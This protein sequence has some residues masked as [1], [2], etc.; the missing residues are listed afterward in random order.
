MRVKFDR[1][2]DAIYVTLRDGVYCR[3]KEL[4]D[5]RRI[6][7]DADGTPIGIELLFVSHGVIVDDLPLSEQVAAELAN[8]KIK[9]FA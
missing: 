5:H 7:Y 4:D 9:V 1:G 3:G 2:A 8:H 6:D